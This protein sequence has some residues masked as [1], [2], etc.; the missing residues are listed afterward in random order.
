M[1]MNIGLTEEIRKAVSEHLCKLLADEYFLYLK[2][3]NFHWNITGESFIAL[4]ELLEKHYEWLK[5]TVDDVA[6]RIRALGY[7]A[8]GTYREYVKNV[9]LAHEPSK[10][11]TALEMIAELVDTHE[12]LIRTIRGIL[13]EIQGQRDYATEDLL[14]K[15]L[16]SHEMKT[17]M[18]RSH[19]LSRPQS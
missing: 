9:E 11:L 13:D 5:G 19:L 1:K 6:E 8:P 4:H 10:D 2:T 3:L 14:I 17:W 15:L 12:A 7:Q 18:L 16:G